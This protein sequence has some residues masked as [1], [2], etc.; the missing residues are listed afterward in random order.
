[1]ILLHRPD[2]D[3]YKTIHHEDEELFREIVS[4]NLFDKE[5][6]ETGIITRYE[7]KL[8]LITDKAQIKKVLDEKYSSRSRTEEYTTGLPSAT[9]I[10]S[11][12]FPMDIDYKNR[13]SKFNI[14][15]WW[16]NT[17][18]EDMNAQKVTNKL[19]L[20][21]GNFL[22]GVLEEAFNSQ[23]RLYVKKRSLDKYIENVCNNISIVRDISNFEDRKIYFVDMAKNVLSKFF[24]SEIE[25]I[26]PVFNEL[27]IKLDGKLQ[28]AID[29]VSIYKGK[30][31]IMD[32][33]TSKKSMSRSQVEDKRYLAQLYIYSRMLLLSNIITKNE[34]DAL[35]FHI[36]FFN[37][38]SG[39]SALYTFTKEEVDKS[40]AYVNFVFDWFHKIMSGREDLSF[41]L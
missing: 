20:D 29:A 37:W 8:E 3:E 19:S 12:L 31:C 21:S 7:N 32:W 17:S 10:S 9:V 28:G 40:K 23:D 25:H 4:N 24:Q 18:L 6:K 15:K 38:N 36:G 14:L 13:A 30:L 2:I 26:T 16:N 34:Y 11:G 1:M 41:E 22:H 39:N 27:F 35:E 33:K 5:D